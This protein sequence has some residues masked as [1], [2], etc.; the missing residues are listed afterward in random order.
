MEREREGGVVCVW[1]GG[2]GRAERGRGHQ[3]DGSR[4]EWT[5]K[6]NYGVYYSYTTK[7]HEYHWQNMTKQVTC[8]GCVV[9]YPGQRYL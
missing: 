8:I 1:G 6:T 7:L 5:H 9:R 2:G 4:S 3:T